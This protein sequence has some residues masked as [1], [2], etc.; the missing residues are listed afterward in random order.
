MECGKVQRVASSGWSRWRA[1]AAVL[2]AVCWVGAAGCAGGGEASGRAAGE[3]EVREVERAGASEAEDTSEGAPVEAF[4]A[5]LGETFSEGERPSCPD[6]WKPVPRTPYAG[7]AFFC[8]GFPG[9]E[10]WGRVPLTVNVEDAAVTVVTVQ[11][12]FEAVETAK[13]RYESI[14]SAR[15]G[16]CDRETGGER[17]IVLNCPGWVMDAAWEST[18]DQGLLKVHWARTLEAL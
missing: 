18:Y 2:G 5:L 1:V 14:V 6:A 12:V 4:Q 16:E 10:S 7:E 9:P 13:E 15:L 8:G 17:N 11:E 3:S